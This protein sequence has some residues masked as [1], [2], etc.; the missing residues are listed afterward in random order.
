ML[1][2]I[3]SFF[4]SGTM[5][6]VLKLL[7]NVGFG[8]DELTDNGDAAAVIPVILVPREGDLFVLFGNVKFKFGFVE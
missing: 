8:N 4:I 1:D 7:I 6:E 3:R 5:L 2:F